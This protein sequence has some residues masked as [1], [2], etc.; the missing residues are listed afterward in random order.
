LCFQS[1]VGPQQWLKPSLTETVERLGREGA[2][3]LIIVPIAFV[4]DHIETLSEIHIE[5]RHAAMSLGVK[6]FDMMPALLTDKRFI[7]C[8][9]E[10]A[11]KNFEDHPGV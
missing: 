5:A 1:K 7:G 9:A 2:S 3:H 10:L 6:Y 8:L 4:T 11:E